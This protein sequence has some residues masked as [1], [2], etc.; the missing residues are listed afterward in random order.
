MNGMSP[1]GFTGPD[2]GPARYRR[3]GDRLQIEDLFCRCSDQR[4]ETH[5]MATQPELTSAQ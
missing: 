2:G 3:V 1:T 4:P 5:M